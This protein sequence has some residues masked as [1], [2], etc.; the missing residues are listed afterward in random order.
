MT[1]LVGDLEN[2]QQDL[3]Q[4]RVPFWPSQVHQVPLAHWEPGS[5]PA[6]RD[7]KRP[8]EFWVGGRGLYSGAGGPGGAQTRTRRVSR[9]L[10]EPRP[11]TPPCAGRGPREPETPPI[12]L[13][14][15]LG[16]LLRRRGGGRAPN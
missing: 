3:H 2:V 11:E 4:D 12:M 15:Q 1:T 10:A 16:A 9:G 13:G 5:D 7:P 14:R 8:R 6:P